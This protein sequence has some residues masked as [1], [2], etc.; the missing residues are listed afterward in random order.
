[1]PPHPTLK[2]L[3]KLAVLLLLNLDMHDFKT[4]P[5][6]LPCS[7]STSSLWSGHTSLL[8]Y[9]A[10]QACCC[11]RAFVCC[12]V[13]LVLCLPDFMYGWCCLF[14]QVTDQESWL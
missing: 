9:E 11:Q 7:A 10:Y 5:S 2:T 13:Y 12:A 1:M 4:V 6:S 14:I 8:S 3:Q